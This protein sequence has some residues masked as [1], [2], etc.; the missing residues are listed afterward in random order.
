MTLFVQLYVAGFV[1][2]LASSIRAERDWPR[3]QRSELLAHATLSLM[4]PLYLL[5]LAAVAISAAAHDQG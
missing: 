1:A 5:F 2:T 3:H 4:W